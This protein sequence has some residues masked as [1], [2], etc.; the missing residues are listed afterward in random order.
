[1]IETDPRIP[2]RFGP[3]AAAGPE[4]ALL[5]AGDAAAPAGIA[6]ARFTPE[7]LGFHGVGCACCA[8]RGAAA[9]ALGRLFLTRARGGV[10]FREVLAVTPGTIGE[11][12][13][14]AAVAGDALTAA[15]FRVLA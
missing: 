11:A 3:A 13:V 8:P 7:P 1:M 14:R 4:T 12:E 2:V 9:A 5:I 15:R 10:W 6:V